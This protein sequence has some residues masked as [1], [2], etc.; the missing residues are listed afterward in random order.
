MADWTHLGKVAPGAKAYLFIGPAQNA[1]DELV[2]RA[3][4]GVHHVR[5]V[6]PPFGADDLAVLLGTPEETQALIVRELEGAKVSEVSAISAYLK[7]PRRPGSSLVLVGDPPVFEDVEPIRQRITKL[8]SATFIDVS[9]PRGD[10]GRKALTAWVGEEWQTT[11]AAATRAVTRADYSIEVLVW[12]TRTFHALTSG[13]PVEGQLA[14]RLVDIAV[15]VQPVDSAYRLLLERD[16]RA[17]EAVAHLSPGQR[18]GLFRRL[19]AA[20]TDLEL[21]HPVFSAGSSV[22]SAASR[23]G[24]SL[25][26]VLEL[27]ACAPRYPPGVVLRCRQILALALAHHTQ[28]ES[29]RI[30]AILWS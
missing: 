1:L 27:A 26:R 22:K 2:R 17:V 12:A 30:A 5:T 29:A 14:S 21:L 28:P 24:V 19:E 16:A 9:D 13:K 8:P 11:T 25:V 23:T 10:V 15:P 3:T 7:A 4:E 18:L 6:H 20:L